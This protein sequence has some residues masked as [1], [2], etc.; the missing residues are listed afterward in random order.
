MA[1]AA[2]VGD[3]TMKEL[4]Q[5]L[6]E[7][8]EQLRTLQDVHKDESNIRLDKRENISIKRRRQIEKHRNRYVKEG[9]KHKAGGDHLTSQQ[10][11]KESF[12][13]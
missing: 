11:T 5:Q 6:V 2:K 7:H 12:R 3:G 10:Q 1:K 8:R 4:E 9:I 13:I